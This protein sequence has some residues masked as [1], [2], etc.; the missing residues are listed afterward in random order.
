MNIWFIIGVGSCT[1]RGYEVPTFA[2]TSKLE[3]WGTNV[4]VPV[5]V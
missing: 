5:V 3:T 1:Y 2:V 4:I